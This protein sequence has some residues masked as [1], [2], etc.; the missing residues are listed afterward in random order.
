MVGTGLNRAGL[1]WNLKGANANIALRCRETHGTL[2]R[3][4]GAAR[5]SSESGRLNPSPKSDLPGSPAAL[6]ARPIPSTVSRAPVCGALARTQFRPALLAQYK[7]S[8]ALLISTSAESSLT[9]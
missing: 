7:A 4:P 5:R 9:F 2:R 6:Q 3:S 1:H 8:S